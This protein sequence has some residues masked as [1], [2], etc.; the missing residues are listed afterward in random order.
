MKTQI[1]CDEMGF[2]ALI[3]AKAIRSDFIPIGRVCWSSF[4][5]RGEV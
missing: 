1:E 4:F 3:S 2:F 5:R